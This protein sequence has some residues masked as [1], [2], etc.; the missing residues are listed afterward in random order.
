V[1]QS[2]ARL[3]FGLLSS[4]CLAWGAQL[5]TNGGFETGNFAGWTVVNQAGT[6][7]GH[8][9][10]VSG[11]TST[12]QSG[13]TTVGPASGSFYAVTDGLGPGTSALL[14]SFTVSGPVSSVILSFSLF[15][16]SYGG[17]FVN[18][19]GLDFTGGA[20]QYGRVDILRAGASAFDTGSGV[21][22]T[23]YLGDDPGANPHAYTSDS[24]NIT[25]LVGGGGTFQLRFAEVD[26]QNTLNMGVDNAS[27]VTTIG[28]VPEP[29]TVIL[30]ALGLAGFSLV[31]RRGRR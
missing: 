1:N 24:F 12:P 13:S 31:I 7:P 19:I 17:D 10:Y 15:V 2:V 6:F 9:F 14:Q 3:T 21:L 27:I 18:P 20:N 23:Y 30:A 25:S 8:N 22:A 28:G 5:I 4:A 16:N 26:N 11:A 29:S